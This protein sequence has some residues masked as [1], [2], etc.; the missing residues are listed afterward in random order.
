M[1]ADVGELLPRPVEHVASGL[2]LGFAG[3]GECGRRDDGGIT[4]AGV[5]L[6]LRLSVGDS[7]GVGGLGLVG[8]VLALVPQVDGFAGL[9]LRPGQ[10]VSEV[11]Q[12]G[13]GGLE[14]IPGLQPPRDFGLVLVVEALG[15]ISGPGAGVDLLEGLSRG[16]GFFSPFPQDASVVEHRIRV[17]RHQ[18]FRVAGLAQFR[19]C[20]V[21]SPVPVG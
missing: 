16:S 19:G 12:C 13:S 14:A 6:G 11:L 3:I 17:A 4:A 2:P 10:T 1:V 20:H 8:G 7:L 15:S 9:A 21:R 18:R 5:G